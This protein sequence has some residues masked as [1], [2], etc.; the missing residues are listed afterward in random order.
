MSK[1]LSL[2]AIGLIA[3]LNLTSCINRTEWLASVGNQRIS[4]HDVN[5]RYEMMKLAN[6]KITQKEAMEQLISY[7]VRSEILAGLGQRIT[8][9]EIATE[10]ETMKKEAKWDSKVAALLRGYQRNHSF[11]EVYLYPKIVD[12]KIKNIFD[13][14]IVFHEKEISVASTLLNRSKAD[15][16]KLEMIAGEMGLPF[17]RGTFSEADK[18]IQWD[19]SRGIASSNFML[20][21]EPW[22]S[23]QLKKEV[24]SKTETGKIFP[25]M[26]PFWFGYLIVRREPSEKNSF[27]F[28]VSIAPRKA[29]W[30]W[31]SQKS[32]L[33][34]ITRF[35]G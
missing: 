7:K 25:E 24:L 15:P 26:V 3:L 8:P 2:V 5:L 20:P 19:T 28:S 32:F 4:K 12:K 33:L 21:K 14:D 35:D 11:S 17:F 1:L 29:L 18:T 31:V 10:I 6:P 22:F 13:N 23:G 27:D 16:T 34:P 9:Q 30:E